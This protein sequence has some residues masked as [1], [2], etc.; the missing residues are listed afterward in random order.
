M[1]NKKT[2]QYLFPAVAGMAAFVG[3]MNEGFASAP[4]PTPTQESIQITYEKNM[5]GAPSVKTESFLSNDD[6]L[7]T[8]TPSDYSNKQLTIIENPF[9]S[10][11]GVTVTAASAVAS[12]SQK[13]TQ[14]IYLQHPNITTPTTAATV[15]LSVTEPRCG[16]IIEFFDMTTFSGSRSY[17]PLLNAAVGT[18][19]GDD[20]Q[21]KL[22]NQP[23]TTI[24]YGP[25]EPAYSDQK[26]SCKLVYK[27]KTLGQLQEMFMKKLSS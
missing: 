7:Y 11:T 25:V 3:M 1:K 12:N 26:G 15:N 24:W 2:K 17:T 6:I 18:N 19:W 5:N 22:L 14:R 9:A 8:V 23:H 16:D 20:I 13:L 10:S 4:P 21:N 27:K